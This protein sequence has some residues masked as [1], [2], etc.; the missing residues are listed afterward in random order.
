MP[1]DP[2]CLIGKLH[3]IPQ[4]PV[5][6]FLAC[7]PNL[8][9]PTIYVSGA[10]TALLSPNSVTFQRHVSQRVIGNKIFAH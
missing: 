3:S 9:D 1:G 2:G 4:R 8:A 7:M 10:C 6:F 5:G